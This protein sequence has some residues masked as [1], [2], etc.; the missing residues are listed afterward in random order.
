MTHAARLALALL[1]ALIAP[2]CQGADGPNPSEG[3]ARLDRPVRV[4]VGTYTNK[5]SKGIYL[6]ELDPKTGTLSEP[7]LAAETKSPSFLALHPNRKVLYAVGE[8][9]EFKGQKTGSVSAFSI[10]DDGTLKLINAQPSG[11]TGPCHLDLDS[12]GRNVVVANYGGGSVA[13]LPVN[14]DGG[15]APPSQVIRH[16][17]KSVNPR[18]QEGPHAH[19]ASV[20]GPHVA[21]AD[22]GLD[23]TFIYQHD[24]ATASLK[25]RTTADARPGSGPRHVARHMGRHGGRN[26]GRNGSGQ[27][28]YVNN[29]LTSTVSVFPAHDVPPRELQNVTTLPAGF[30]GSKNSTAEIAVHPTGRFLY[31]SNRG[32]DS[33]AAFTIHRETG[34]LT[35]AGHFSTHGKTPRNFAI[36]PS[37]QFLLA[38]NQGSDTVVVFRIDPENGSLATAG[39]TAA[40]PTPVCVLFVP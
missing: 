20:F 3:S 28:M 24:P 15:L 37:G 10:N 8:S 34:R 6:M 31:V 19:S 21:V 5:A 11:G 12:A 13:V 18:R 27:W 26:G 33:I 35:P 22:L 23:K 1:L 16:E 4:Y 39:T 14:N 7:K 32:H 30:D 40:V 2:G 17:G 25:L 29:E 36:D 38:A 9:D